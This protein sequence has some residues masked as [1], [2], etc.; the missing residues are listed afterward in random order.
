M[1]RGR[2]ACAV[3]FALLAW[4]GV[5]PV[6]S[7]VPLFVRLSGAQYPPSL[8]WWKLTTP[9]F[10]VLYPDS[11]AAEAQRAAALLERAYVP[12]GKTLDRAPERIAVV[13]NNQSA[14]SNAFVSWAPRRSEWYALPP[15]GL[16]EFGPVDWFSLLAVHEGR[17]VVQ[18]RAIRD[19]WVGLLSRVFGE[20]TTA[21]V[22]GALYFPPWFW[23]GDAVGTETALTNA[24]RGRQP[25]FANRVRTMR[26]NGERYPYYAAWGG[27]YRT[28]YPDWYQLGYLLTTHVKRQYGADTWR[29][30]VASASWWPI[31]PYALSRGLKKATGKTLTV[32]HREAIQEL[33]SL[34]RTQVASLDTTAATILSPRQPDY[35]SWRLPQYAGDGSIIAEYWDMSSVP[36]LVRLKNGRQETLVK[37]F[38]TRGEQQFDVV[39]NLVVWSE[40]EVDPR[41]VQR[42]YL[43][44]RVLDLSTGAIRT[45]A[46]GSRH[47]GAVLS[48]D[49]RAIAAVRFTES[50]HTVLD[51]LDAQSGALVRSLPNEADHFLA[52]PAWSPDGGSV[53]CVAVDR[54]TERGNALVRIGLADGA[55]DTVIA[56][57]EDAIVRPVVRGTWVYYGSPSSGID[58]IEAM[59]LAT[60]KRYQVTSRRYGAKGATVSHDGTRL[61][62]QD[63]GVDGYNIAEAPIDTTRLVPVDDSRSRTVAYYAPLMS[64]EDVAAATAP[65]APGAWPVRPYGGL[66]RAF[67]FHSLSVAP[68]SDAHNRGLILQSRNILNTTALSVGAIAN[69]PERTAS[70]ELGASYAAFL[71]IVDGALRIGTRASVADLDSVRTRYHW[72]ERSAQVG[73]RLP[74]VRVRGLA[75]ERIAASASIGAT[76]VDGRTIE[77]RFSNNNGDFYPMTYTLSASHFAESATRDI[78]PRGVLGSLVYRHTPFDGDY[79]G[80]QLSVYG[81]LYLP[82]LMRHHG[83]LLEGEREEQRR[84]NYLFSSIYSV[85]RGYDAFT[86]ERSYRLGA[87][88]AF[89]LF[90]PDFALGPLAYFRRV[91]GAVFYDYGYAARRDN[92]VYLLLRSTGA[93]VTTDMSPIQLRSTMRVGLR[94]NYRVD[95]LPHVRT[96]V[97]I[98]LPF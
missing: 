66:E 71:P 12:L 51:V 81:G 38:A 75:T 94:M 33:D 93:E 61:L 3:V 37:Q 68:T 85:S 22:G 78:L 35:H 23:E 31:P 24:G 6:G 7:Q 28:F 52:S 67:A 98:S 60:G 57:R 83:L 92:S 77:S 25:W 96:N 95:D 43:T 36:S 39:G 10:D 72:N 74:F 87:T 59:S 29:K 53:Y 58:N 62:F 42:G 40:L 11:M 73:V 4:A 91:Q 41:F 20:G 79:Q 86:A 32:L 89:P 13:L 63:Y 19:G 54:R 14:F 48:P 84:V 47:F 21:F 50:G 70:L 56:F 45:L 88:Y 49:G 65:L 90:Y 9:H 55:A 64:Q 2:M 46:H 69:L 5:M 44:L 82:G 27:S 8:R 15:G 26:L 97:L 80:H 76:H 1:G 34:W 18:E 30:A 17:H 16:D